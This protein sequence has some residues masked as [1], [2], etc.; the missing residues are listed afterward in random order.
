MRKVNMYQFT[1]F[2][3]KANLA[4]NNAVSC[5]EDMGHTYIGSEHIIAGL[6]KDT[7]SVA[8]VVLRSRHIT[9]D[10]LYDKIKVTVGVGVPT[11]LSVDDMTPRC[12]NIVENAVSL[13][14][15]SNNMITGTEHL[16]MA[17]LR[18]GKCIGSRL[19]SQ[20]GV[21]PSEMCADITGAVPS[22]N[23]A[24]VRSARSSQTAFSRGAP[25]VLAKYG[26]DLTDEAAAGHIDPVCSRDREIERVIRILCRRTKNNPCLIGEPGVGK[27]AIAEGLALRIASGN[28]PENLKNTRLCSLD[29]TGMVAG[30]KY[31]GDFEERI[32]NAVREVKDAGN[33]ILFIDEIHNLIGAG[34]AEGAVDAANILKPVLARGEIRLIGATTF[35]EYR[36]NIEK[37]AALERRFQTVPV[38]EPSVEQTVEIL[39]ELRPRYEA[40][41]RVKIGDDAISAAAE[42]SVR[43]ITDRFLPD[44][45]ID[46]MDEAASGVSLEKGAYPPEVGKLLAQS[47]KLNRE[48]AEAVSAQDFEKAVKIREREKEINKQLYSAKAQWAE[49]GRPLPSVTAGDIAAAV[50]ERT[51][52]PAEKLTQEEKERL[53]GLEERLSRKITGQDEAVKKVAAAVRRGRSGIKDPMR[54]VGSFLFCGPTGVGKTALAKELAAELY[55]KADALIRFD[56]SEFAEKHTVSSLI[57]APPGYVGFEE[58]GR[59]VEQIRRKPYS[60]ILFDEIEKAHPDIFSSLLQILDEGFLVSS[61]G[62][63]AD[64]RNCIF[65]LTSNA[66]ASVI[67]NPSIGFGD[68]APDNNVRMKKAVMTELKKIF[69]PEFLNRI[70]ETVIFSRLKKEDV[71]VIAEKY[72]SETAGR[73]EK[74]GWKTVFGEDVVSFLAEKGYD[75]EYGARYLKRLVVSSI[76]DPLASVITD[77]LPHPKRTV[78]FSVDGDELRCNAS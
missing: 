39:K 43:Y 30:A 5:A 74:L 67:G 32:K 54:P 13:A 4:L 59:L 12:R 36:R 37:D 27:T 58:G 68:A 56:M 14:C 38:D 31:R 41:H 40:H 49:E 24:D 3:E 42:L 45:A 20:L 16:L 19:L 73:A 25:S 66:G 50:S 70:D 10:M 65:I 21:V 47:E 63:R 53:A 15:S 51:G 28:V 7:S 23:A 2:S 48:K 76:E 78:V 57:G 62:R 61:D 6:L 34:S 46:L 71:A 75:A 17:V 64:C 1:G 55:G 52:I 18:D 9:Y 22:D 29:L 44:K 77:D 11:Q 72:L 33:V 35:D 69:S 8:G 26:S 60:V